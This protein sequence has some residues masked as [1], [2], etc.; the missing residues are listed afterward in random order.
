MLLRL[1]FVKVSSFRDRCQNIHRR[2]YPVTGD[3][4]KIIQW[5]RV[6]KRAYVRALVCVFV[7]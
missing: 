3:C 5:R 6:E 2:N 7:C 4:F 1:C